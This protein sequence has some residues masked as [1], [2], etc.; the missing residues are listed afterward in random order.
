MNYNKKLKLYFYKEFVRTRR[1]SI[2]FIERNISECNFNCVDKESKLRAKTRRQNWK[3][4]QFRETERGK[5]MRRHRQER[6]NS[7]P[8]ERERHK[9]SYWKGRQE[10]HIHA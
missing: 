1:F 6:E 8:T 2:V 3:E 4:K 9:R 5:G 10:R 7:R